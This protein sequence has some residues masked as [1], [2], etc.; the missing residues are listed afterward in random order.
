MREPALSAPV[1]RL[2][3]PS[4]TAQRLNGFELASLILGTSLAFLHGRSRRGGFLRLM[5]ALQTLANHGGWAILATG[6]VGAGGSAAMSLP[7]GVA[8]AED[9]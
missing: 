2:S 7:G 9:S 5:R 8:G 4:W 1:H 3:G 6:L